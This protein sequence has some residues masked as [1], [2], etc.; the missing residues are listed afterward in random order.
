M[1]AI[2]S[3]SWRKIC[4]CNPIL[5]EFWTKLMSNYKTGLC[6]NFEFW[7]W[8]QNSV[9][10]SEIKIL[11]LKSKLLFLSNLISRPKNSNL[12][13]SIWSESSSLSFC[14]ETK[15]WFFMRFIYCG[16]LMEISFEQQFNFGVFYAWTQLNKNILSWKMISLII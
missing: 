15:S 5:D 13:P 11:D 16:K 12:E 4:V 9:L 7:F 6:Q 10:E 3:M 8:I 2:K 14:F 1:M